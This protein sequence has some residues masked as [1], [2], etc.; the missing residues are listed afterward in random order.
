MP[1]PK[2]TYLASSLVTHRDDE[3]H[4]WRTR[5]GELVPRLATEIGHVVARLRNL[6]D[7]ERIDL[8]GR[9]TS[10]AECMEAT[11]P[12]RGEKCFRHHAASGVTRAEEQHVVRSGFDHKYLRN[13][14]WLRMIYLYIQSNGNVIGQQPHF[15]DITCCTEPA[16]A[17]QH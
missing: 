17:S 14:L 4:T 13:G 12:Q 8:S 9:M 16:P 11:L 15:D 2:G 10:C 3:V 5:F 1:G 7:C 6:F